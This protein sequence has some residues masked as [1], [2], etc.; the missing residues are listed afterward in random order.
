MEED[1]CLH[2]PAPQAWSIDKN[3]TTMKEVPALC[4]EVVAHSRRR[5][6]CLNTQCVWGQEVKTISSENTKLIHFL[7][8]IYLEAKEQKQNS[9]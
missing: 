3:V 4:P 7:K 5:L 2:Q 1:G 8:A 6:P 9:H